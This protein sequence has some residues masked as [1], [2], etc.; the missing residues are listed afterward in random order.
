M[1][2]FW[3]GRILRQ[4][5]TFDRKEPR[6]RRNLY[7]GKA[8][9][10]SASFYAGCEA[11]LSA[12]ALHRFVR[13]PLELD[14]KWMGKAH[15]TLRHDQACGIRFRRNPPLRA[16]ASAPKELASR[17]LMLERR[18]LQGQRSREP[19]PFALQLSER[20]KAYPHALRQ[21]VGHHQLDRVR[22]EQRRA[23]RKQAS[24]ER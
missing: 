22:L 19:V 9:G 1:T 20:S 13:E 4:R 3:P 12:F 10:H 6:P 5:G 11:I 18:R 7:G 2:E 17:V 16:C 21:L 14:R 8:Y 15:L 23:V 24:N